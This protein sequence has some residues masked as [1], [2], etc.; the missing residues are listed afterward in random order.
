LLTDA[1]YAALRTYTERDP[2]PG[3]PL[4][5]PRGRLDAIFRIC[6][7]NTPWTRIST[8]HGP[9]ATI[10]RHFRR[11]AHAGIWT[12]LLK[13]SRRRRAPKPLRRLHHWIA[14]VFRRCLSLLGLA[15]VELAR[16]LRAFRAIPGPLWYFPDPNL[17]EQVNAILAD[18][19]KKP[20][21]PG[22]KS[23]TTPACRRCSRS[24]AACCAWPTAAAPCPAAWCPSRES[25]ASGAAMRRLGLRAM[26]WCA[27]R[28]WQY[29]RGRAA[30][31]PIV[32]SHDPPF[33]ADGRRA[34]NITFRAPRI[35]AMLPSACNPAWPESRCSSRRWR[36][37]SSWTPSSSCSRRISPCRR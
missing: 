33:G 23:P 36:P 21:D 7:T 13:A 31:A 28:Q 16:R 24:A 8:D 11:L 29:G 4:K 2:G 18:A 26:H 10:H 9:T 27:G 6:L 12:A 5:D 34:Q 19:L 35:P 37:S 3:R 15:A 14:A 1:E 32:H 20:D 30:R 17:S 22:L 25:C